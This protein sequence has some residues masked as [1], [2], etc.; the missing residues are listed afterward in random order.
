MVIHGAIDGYSRL[1]LYLY[2]V[3]NNWADT[4]LSC[5]TM[6]LQVIDFQ[7]ESGWI[8]GAKTNLLPD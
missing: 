6:Q 1:V 3:D 2:C 5:F 4:V 8:V 7:R